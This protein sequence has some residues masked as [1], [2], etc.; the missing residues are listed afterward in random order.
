MKNIK[1]YKK[2]IKNIIFSHWKLLLIILLILIALSVVVWKLSGFISFLNT[3]IIGLFIGLLGSFIITFVF[4]INKQQQKIQIREY[5]LENFIYN[6]SDFLCL[7]ESI[8]VEMEKTKIDIFNDYNKVSKKLLKLKEDFKNTKIEDIR[9]KYRSLVSIFIYLIPPL[10]YSYIKL[11]NDILLS[12]NILNLK[13]YSYFNNQI[14][15]NLFNDY[16]TIKK[17][18]KYFEE[19][20][21][22]FVFNN[23]IMALNTIM[24]AEKIFPEI[25]LKYNELKNFYN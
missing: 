7:I 24:D 10:Y 23:I 3:I 17:E 8:F 16:L 6:A 13:E 21:S 2:I 12:N 15:N 25:K 11:N 18:H 19:C 1:N 20:N 9:K 4:E 14:L 5:K 22:E